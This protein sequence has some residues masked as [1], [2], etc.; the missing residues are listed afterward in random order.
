MLVSCTNPRHQ[1]KGKI[2]PYYSKWG[3][4]PLPSE[5]LKKVSNIHNSRLTIE[6]KED[7]V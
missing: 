2:H 5:A 3:G 6:G 7:K 4:F 1:G